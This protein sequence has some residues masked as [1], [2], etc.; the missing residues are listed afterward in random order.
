MSFV[1]NNLDETNRIVGGKEARPHSWPSIVVL[2][3][4]LKNREFTWCGGTLISKNEI[5]T[6]AQ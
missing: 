5:L 3:A 6:A 2:Y 1:P 4:L